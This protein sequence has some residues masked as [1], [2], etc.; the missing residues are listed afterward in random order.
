M[1]RGPALDAVLINESPMKRR[2]Q[3]LYRGDDILAA[4]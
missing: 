1:R 3:N 2:V 4:G